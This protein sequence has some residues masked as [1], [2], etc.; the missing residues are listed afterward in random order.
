MKTY[1]KRFLICC[2]LLAATLVRAEELSVIPVPDKVV[3]GT[4]EWIVRKSVTIS[5]E[6]AQLRPAAEY[7]SALLGRAT[8]YR[9]AITKGK[10]DIH[11]ALSGEGRDGSYR[12]D[13]TPKGVSVK[14]RDYRGVIYG[15]ATLRQLLPDDIESGQVVRR[16]WSVPCLT[17]QDSPRFEWRGM[18]LD[19]S[20]HFFTTGEIKKLLDVL[21]LYKI[22]KMHWHLTDDQGWRVEIKRYPL[23]TEKGAWRTYNNQDT[24]CM[25]RAVEED[26]PDMEIQADKTRKDAEGNTV[27]GGFYTQAEI[28]DIVAYATVRGIEIIP[29]IDMPGHS[30]VPIENYAGLSCFKE[31]GWGRFFTTPMCPGKDA[32]LDFCKNVWSELF[33]LFPSKF[34]H[35]GGD[36]VDMK[37]WK[38]CPDC[39]KRMKDNN[40][41]DV[42]QLQTWFNRCMEDFFTAHGK[43]MIGWDEIIDGGLTANSTVMWWR[44]WA[45]DSP[46]RATSHGNQVICTPNSEFYIDYQETAASIPAIYDFDPLKGLDEKERKLVLG[47]QGNL[48]TEWVPSFRR[49]WYQAFPRML[50]VAELGWSK[51]EHKSV[52]DFEKRMANHLA[53]LHKLGVTYRIPDL[54]GFHTTNV[55]IDKGTVDVRCADASA[56]I[57]YTTDGTMPQV[58]SPL[59]AGA[60]TIDKTTHFTFRT[61]GADNRK[62]DVVKCSYVKEDYAPAVAAGDRKAGLSVSWHDYDGIE[63]AGIDTAKVNGTYVTP[64]VQIPSEAKG[65]IGLVITGYIE[66]PADGIYTFALLSDDGSYLKI[67]DVMVVDNDK[68]HSPRELLGQHA[69]KRGLHPIHVRYFDHNGGKLALRVMDSE[70]HPV[71]VRYWH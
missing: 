66:V 35:I 65:N 10:G 30:L 16:K 60:M 55:F 22:S 61:F 71:Q 54:T 49:M 11:I 13:V 19:C 69:M 24:V 57:R 47:V 33:E 56:V 25:K 27:Y 28:K 48:W 15:I 43:T 29:E 23:L 14:G 21:A 67:D 4:G 9:F 42:S 68:E 58:N 36:E 31:I 17:V 20:R 53:R 50:A 45:P 41:K 26:A 3:M 34:A 51:P 37:N 8:G 2:L 63:C 7:L 59:Y 12:L 1:L 70:G 18:E 5:C 62:G 32:V 39:Q 6:N 46:K 64:G 40:L 38:V 52:A 44:S